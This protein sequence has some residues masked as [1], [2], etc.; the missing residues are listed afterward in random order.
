MTPATK[1]L[2]TSIIR[3]LKGVIHAWERWLAQQEVKRT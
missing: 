1:E 2:H 3:L